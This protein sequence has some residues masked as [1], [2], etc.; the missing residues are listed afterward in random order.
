MTGEGDSNYVTDISTAVP[1]YRTT[2]ILFISADWI[3][4]TE[5]GITAS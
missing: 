1:S 5:L 3:S 4:D 2:R